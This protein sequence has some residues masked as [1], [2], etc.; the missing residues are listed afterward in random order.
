MRKRLGPLVLVGVMCITCACSSGESTNN[1]PDVK[2]ET[3]ETT[4]GDAIGQDAEIQMTTVPQEDEASSDNEET[5][6]SNSATESTS[7][8]ENTTTTE[9]TTTEKQTTTEKE[10][11]TEK[12]TTTEKQT[13]TQKQTTTAKQTTTSQIA[14]VGQETTTNSAMTGSNRGNVTLDIEPSTAATNRAA[15]I[16]NDIITDSMS[17]YQCVLAIHDYLV[18]NV[19]YGFVGINDALGTDLAHKAEGAL[20]YDTAVCQGYAEAFELLCSQVGIQAYM[21]YGTAGTAATGYESHAWNIVK[22]NG[23]WYHIDCTWDDPTVNGGIV[24][25]G[26]NII[27]Q[28]FLLTDAEMYVDHVVDKTYTTNVKACTS[29]LFKGVGEKMT[30][31]VAMG[32]PSKIVLTAKAFYQVVESYV[33]QNLL[34]FYIAVPTSE[35]ISQESLGASVSAGLTSAGITGQYGISYVTRN[36]VGYVVYHITVSK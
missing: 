17:D 33:S 2:P 29:T 20:C 30:L 14:T 28:Y 5:T 21:M 1:E 19:D 16:V 27:Y 34:D 25:D 6:E 8:I 24:T 10:T 36:V 9:T 31:E 12:H 13:T 35:A 26:S 11:T 15:K 7:D 3:T 32:E 18:K 4:V 23:E 22:I